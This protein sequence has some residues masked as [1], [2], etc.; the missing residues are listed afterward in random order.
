[1]WLTPAESESQSEE[2]EEEARQA[3]AAK[4]AQQAQQAGQKR[5]AEAAA[6]AAAKQPPAKAA[7]QQAAATPADK[8]QAAQQQAKT[9]AT[10]P[11]KQA[12]QAQQA[13]QAPATAPAKQQQKE[14]QKEAAKPKVLPKP[15]NV[16]GCCGC[17][18][19]VKGVLQDWCC[20]APQQAG[21]VPAPGSAADALSPLS[22]YLLL[23]V[24]SFPNGFII[25]DLKAVSGG[26]GRVQF[27]LCPFAFVGSLCFIHGNLKAASGAWLRVAASLIN[28]ATVTGCSLLLSVSPAH[29]CSNWHRLMLLICAGPPR[30]QAG[31][32][33]Q[34]G[35]HAVSAGLASRVVC[36]V[37]SCQRSC[38]SNG[39]SWRARRWSCGDYW[40]A[41]IGCGCMAW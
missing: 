17:W 26:W 40:P 16:P 35:G 15:C 29:S 6:A 30:R 14:Q 3:A 32:G 38:Y 41:T 12:Q 10:A 22:A 8:K 19:M 24:R 18:F 28:P 36:L 25:E 27:A 39:A 7:K 23:Q 1:M 31:Q 37:G 4:Q 33:G 13:Q 20:T 2:E 9:P 21:G 34:E 5:K 11:A